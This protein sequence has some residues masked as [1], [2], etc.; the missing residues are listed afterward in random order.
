MDK[1][2]SMRKFILAVIC[3]ILLISVYLI[4]SANN[5]AFSTLVYGIAALYA[6]FCGGNSM[7]YIQ[8]ARRLIRPLISKDDT[9]P[10][11]D[12]GTK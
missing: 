5:A 9:D 12:D 10:E 7:E 11:D 2:V 4:D 6:A 1:L 8:K 3:I